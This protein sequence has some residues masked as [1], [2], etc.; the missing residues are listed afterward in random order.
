MGKASSTPI[1]S[2]TCNENFHSLHSYDSLGGAQDSLPPEGMGNRVDVSHFTAVAEKPLDQSSK[3]MATVAKT[4]G[5]SHC[6]EPCR[7]SAKH[8]Q[9]PKDSVLESLGTSP[10]STRSG[11]PRS[12]SSP[13]DSSPPSPRSNVNV[14]IEE[15][16]SPSLSSSASEHSLSPHE[17]GCGFTKR[18]PEQKKLL[19]YNLLPIQNRLSWLV[20]RSDLT[21]PPPRPDA[22]EERFETFIRL[23]DEELLNEDQDD[24]VVA[25]RLKSSTRTYKTRRASFPAMTPVSHSRSAKTLHTSSKEIRR[26]VPDVRQIGRE[27]PSK[28]PKSRQSR[29]R[30][31][32]LERS[33]Q[34][35]KH[36]VQTLLGTTSDSLVIATMAKDLLFESLPK[37]N[38]H[39]IHV[40][41]L[42]NDKSREAFLSVLR[43]EGNRTG[44]IRFAWHLAGSASAAQAIE[45]DGIRCAEGHCHCGRYGR[46]GY[47]ATSASKANAYA[48]SD[49]AGG[50]RCLFLVLALPEK[51]VIRGECGT[52]P[53]KTAA[54]LPSYPTEYCFVD[55]ARLHCVCRVDYSWAPTGMRSK[56]ATAGGHCRAWRSGSGSPRDARGALKVTQSRTQNS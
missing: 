23:Q 10:G 39:D 2:R 8:L 40:V 32:N 6:A 38:V 53:A 11:T 46:G 9:L 54:D 49:C 4:P 52:R 21:P 55:E 37:E 45:I 41:A 50:E 34:A 25:P 56:I 33:P 18:S 35:S 16:E 43:A 1:K 17:R 28:T 22:E 7:R 29:D 31:P 47:V 51:E 26:S 30:S 12:R 48:D 15:D 14:H 27:G 3:F 36:L 19:P 24:I 13:E 20:T 44:R 5:Q 42:Q